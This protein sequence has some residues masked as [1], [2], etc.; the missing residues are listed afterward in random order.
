MKKIAIL[1]ST[2]SIGRNALDVIARHKDDFKVVGLTAQDNAELLAR[3][4]NRFKARL[5]AL[6]NIAGYTKLKRA[7]KRKC[8]VLKGTEGIKEV[9]SMKEADIVLI[10]ISGTS[11]LHPLISAIRAKKKIALANKESIVSAGDR[12]MNM[13]RASRAQ[14]IPV[15]SE[16]NSIF[17]CLK[18]ES[19]KNIDKIFLIGS[20]GPLKD[21]SASAFD[22]L[23][24]SRVLAHPIWKMGRKISVDSATMMNK[25][26]EVI[27]A[28][29]LF[30][31]DTSKIEVLV[32]PQAVI[33]S[34]VE[35]S[36]GNLVS[37][38][39][40]PDMRI[41]IYYA[42]T[43]PE[44]G[45][46]LLPKLNFSK[47]KNITFQKPDTKK[48]PALRLCYAAAKKGGTYPACLNAANEEAVK[49]YL[50]GKIKFTGI[51]D[52]VKKVLARHKSISRP[53]IGEI[54]RVDK[55]AKE[56]VRRLC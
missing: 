24:P 28:S 36:D 51:V 54:F 33:H 18:G 10:A 35:F 16:H 3:Q 8:K 56:E 25:G 1:G 6:G 52:I 14:I 2:G 42:F 34:V 11:A 20:G 30:D 9:A 32:H 13:A 55:W 48:F 7:L 40:C 41:P 43:H 31:I 26:L 37:N 49:L 27:E 53:S 46:S 45:R 23:K 17:Q 5:L 38:L 22:K 21:V 19:K 12:I 15:D 39:F 44:R 29:H 47:I 4:A 50:N